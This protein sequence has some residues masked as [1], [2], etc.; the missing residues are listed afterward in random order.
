[1]IGDARA[2]LD[3]GNVMNTKDAAA[4]LKVHPQTLRRYVRQGLVRSYRVGHNL[5][6]ERGALLR[7][8]ARDAGEMVA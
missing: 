2:T 6:F 7:F 1:M 4:L 3:L 5:R 8:L